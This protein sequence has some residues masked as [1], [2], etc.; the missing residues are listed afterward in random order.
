MKKPVILTALLMIAAVALGSLAL[1]SDH[2]QFQKALAKE[3]SEGNLEEAIGLYQ[4]V[5]DETKDEALA[6]QAQ[7]RIGFC[8]EKLGHEKAQLA[9]QAFQKV[10]DKYPA[11]TETARTAREKL[12]LLLKGQA[13]LEKG[14]SLTSLRLVWEGP[15]V[16][17]M[18][19]VSP[20][21]R[22][23]CYTDWETGDLAVHDLQTGGKRRLTGQTA[24]DGS[25]AESSRWSLDGRFIAYTWDM[26][27]TAELR[28][29]GLD[30]AKPRALHQGGGYPSVKDWSPDGRQI[31][32]VIYSEKGDPSFS[33]IAVSD[34]SIRHLKKTGLP[35][36]YMNGQMRFSPDGRYIAFDL[37]N[38]IDLLSTDGKTEGPL[39]RHPAN[40]RLLGWTPDGNHILFASDRSG[41]ID[42]WILPVTEGRPGGEAE[43]LRKD[44]GEISPLGLTRDGAFFYGHG[45]DTQK[46]YLASLDRKAGAFRATYERVEL[47]YEGRNHAPEFSP[48]GKRLAYIRQAVPRMDGSN[49]LCVFSPETGEEKKTALHL[50]QVSS[51]AWAPDGS[52]I[53]ISGFGE[54]RTFIG[55]ID[56]GTGEIEEIFP[57]DKDAREE[58][59]MSP[60]WSPDGQIVYCIHGVQLTATEPSLSIIAKDLSTDRTWDVYKMKAPFNFPMI[61]VSPDGQW[62]ASLEHPRGTTASK[63][64]ILK[65]IST[66]NGEARELG[67][68]VSGTGNVVQPRWSA[69][70]RYIFFPGLRK[71]EER[72]DIWYVSVEGG[73]PRKLGLALHQINYI[74]PLSDGS[75][76]VFSSMGPTVHGPEVWIMENFLPAGNAQARDKR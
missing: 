16:E 48:D 21:G 75:R 59:Y 61:S 19:E 51:V 37:R 26:G 13:A 39:V 8:Y 9:Q 18:G 60:A 71:G 23:I 33:L 38:D 69:D 32:A 43:L 40:E 4:K 70:G 35:A 41:A 56:P 2:D 42:A 5:I 46:I 30:D 62:L 65:V 15:D 31:L 47:P 25:W 52:S 66:E 53:M 74:S 27:V 76:I 50:Q 11:Q 68:F 20:D 58:L 64:K 36:G 44:I 28:I 17:L 72:W 24:W 73:E 54:M 3:R 67:R 55:R 45:K 12:A 29:I 57:S 7:L 14:S 34:G 6:A 22:T 1:Q 63:E 10:V 49:A